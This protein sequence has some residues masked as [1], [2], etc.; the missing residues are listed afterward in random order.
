MGVDGR[1]ERESSSLQLIVVDLTE[2]VNL[3]SFIL[4][5]TSNELESGTFHCWMTWTLRRISGWT[6]STTA[7]G[8]TPRVWT[9]LT[10]TLG[11]ASMRQDAS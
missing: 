2:S 6:L 11:A 1:Q 10:A 9:L 8:A 7:E 5:P 4:L 3:Y